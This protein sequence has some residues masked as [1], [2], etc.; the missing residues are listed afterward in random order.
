MMALV[1]SRPTALSAFWETPHCSPHCEGFCG[2]WGSPLGSAGWE[3][4]GVFARAPPRLVSHTLVYFP[5]W[6][7]LF[8]T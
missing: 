3:L 1:P 7:Q 2:A 4:P 8:H 6:T 5:F